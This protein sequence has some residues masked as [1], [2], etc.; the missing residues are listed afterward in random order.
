L[1]ADFHRFQR[2]QRFRRF[3]KTFVA[4]IKKKQDLAFSEQPFLKCMI[5]FPLIGSLKSAQN[6]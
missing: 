3:R 4:K 2:F 6:P 1:G 5:S